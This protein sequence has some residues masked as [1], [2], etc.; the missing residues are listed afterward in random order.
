MEIEEWS[1]WCWR[2]A[3]AA[4]E[5][6]KQTTSWHWHWH[7]VVASA[8]N[9][10]ATQPLTQALRCLTAAAAAADLESSCGQEWILFH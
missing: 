9:E 1:C 6:T 10:T 2:I 3:A 7:N 5:N 4:A 8:E